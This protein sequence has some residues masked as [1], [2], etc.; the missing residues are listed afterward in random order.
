MRKP[1]AKR[2]VSYERN[3]CEKENKQP[4]KTICGKRGRK[5]ND[6]KMILHGCEALGYFARECL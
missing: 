6:A 5:K 1:F 4:K 2:K 3:P